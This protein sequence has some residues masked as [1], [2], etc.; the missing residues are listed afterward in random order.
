MKAMT[1]KRALRLTAGT[2]VLSSLALGWLHSPY[3]LAL[4]AFAGLNLFQSAF[5]NWCPAIWVFRRLGLKPC[6]EERP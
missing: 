3:W 1:I 6:T 5:T 4:N 2:V